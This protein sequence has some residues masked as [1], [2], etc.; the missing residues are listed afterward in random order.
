MACSLYAFPKTVPIMVRI[1]VLGMAY[2]IL[3][4]VN[5]FGVFWAALN[6]LLVY[7]GSLEFIGVNFLAGGGQPGDGV[8]D[9]SDDQ[10]ETYLLRFVNAGKISECQQKIETLPYF[11]I[12]G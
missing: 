1:C 7:T 10:C 3:M 12:D 9:G 4:S 8:C 11:C 6:S 5:G 2:G